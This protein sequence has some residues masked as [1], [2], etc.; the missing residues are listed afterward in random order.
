MDRRNEYLLFNANHYVLD[1]ATSTWTAKN[2]TGFTSFDGDR[3][4]TDGTNIYYSYAA[5]HYVLDVATSTWT[6]KNWTGLTSFDGN[7]I[8]TDGTNIY[9]SFGANQ[10]VLDVATSTWS[11][12]TWTGLTNLY[13]DRIWTDGT[14][15]YYSYNANHY[16]LD[17]ATSTWTAKNWTG[18]SGFSGNGIWTDGTNIYY[19]Y[20]AIQYVLIPKQ[21]ISRSGKN[22]LLETISDEYQLRGSANVLTS[23]W[24]ADS[25]YAAY[26]YRA[27]VTVAN[28][29][30]KH[31]GLINFD[32]TTLA[33]GVMKDGGKTYDGGFYIYASA[34]PSSTITV[35]SYVFWR[36]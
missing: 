15:I 9:Y 35:E 3:I 29:T 33:L 10:Y 12:K 13:G 1:V 18:L 20:N 16:V 24:A 28:L 27:A 32:D 21:S 22:R 5:I 17:V 23:A 11:V 25:T 4:W 30:A 2:W 34:V 36:T 26:P 7:S 19:S 8:W 14:N 6:A 31:T